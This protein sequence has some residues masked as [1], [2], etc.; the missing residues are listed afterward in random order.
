MYF[1]LRH[2]SKR[3]KT[4]AVFFSRNVLFFKW[5]ISFFIYF[6]NFDV[7]LHILIFAIRAFWLISDVLNFT[8]FVE[9]LKRS[10]VRGGRY[11]LIFQPKDMLKCLNLNESQPIYA[12]KCYSY[13]NNVPAFLANTNH[14]G[15]YLHY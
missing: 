2:L 12:Y 13:K 7:F 11:F 4:V 14:F 5:F 3:Y 8:K 1:H 9:F 6:G 15:S 10:A